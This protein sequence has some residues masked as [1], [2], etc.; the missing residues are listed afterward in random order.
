[1]VWS[2]SSKWDDGDWMKFCLNPTTQPWR[3]LEGKGPGLVT[4][5]WP[6]ANHFHRR[7]LDTHLKSSPSTDLVSVPVTSSVNCGD[8]PYLMLVFL[9]APGRGWGVDPAGT[10]T[11]FLRDLDQLSR[12][13]SGRGK[14][15]FPIKGADTQAG[16]T[17]SALPRAGLRHF[18]LVA[19]RERKERSLAGG[20]NHT[21]MLLESIIQIWK[22]WESLSD[23]ASCWLHLLNH[24]M[25]NASVGWVILCSSQ[26]R[27]SLSG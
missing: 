26:A 6:W 8:W 4:L 25:S 12:W 18:P 23:F 17:S 10:L 27:C 2:L 21:A 20:F 5:G 22:C 16:Q 1:M 15:F 14:S 13:S 7:G 11:S 24:K 3:W 9:R 19:W